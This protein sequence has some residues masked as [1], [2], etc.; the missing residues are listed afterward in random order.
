MFFDFILNLVYI[1]LRNE[2]RDNICIALRYKITKKGLKDDVVSCKYI[3]M[4]LINGI[5][6]VM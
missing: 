5:H 4:C 2:N 3:K 6:I 1:L